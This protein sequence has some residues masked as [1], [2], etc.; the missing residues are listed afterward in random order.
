MSKNTLTK[1]E[2]VRLLDV[3]DLTYTKSKPTNPV[4]ER[5]Q[6]KSY[7]EGGSSTEYKSGDHLVV[8]LQTGTEFIDPLQS[9]LVFDIQAEGVAGKAGQIVGSALNFIRNSQ[10]S[11][12]SGKEMDRV[13]NLNLLQYHLLRNEPDDFIKHNTNAMMLS[14]YNFNNDNMVATGFRKRNE[15]PVDSAVRVMIPLKYISSIFDSEKYM[16][17]HLARGLRI[18]CELEKF[19][20]AFYDALG[21]ATLTGYKIT[22]AFVLTDNYRMADSVLDYLNQEFASKK[23][24]LVY[25]YPSWHTTKSV[26][27]TNDV[28]VEIRRSVSMA[29]DA[30]ACT[31]DNAKKSLVSA[32]SFA[33][34]KMLDSDKSQWRIGSHYL[35]NQQICGVVEHYTQSLYWAN[36]LRG[37]M[38][39]GPDYVHWEG[40]NTSTTG[41]GNS[42]NYGLNKFCATLQRNAIMD[43]SGIQINNSM[44]LACNITLEDQLGTIATRDIN[45]FL[46]HQRRAVLYLENVVLET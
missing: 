15:V 2:I 29:L 6:K 20:T 16:P 23:M 4:V 42:A 8:H 36:K 11:S 31:R 37:D 13:E 12:R 34:V 30:F 1:D 18:D 38:E 14:Q 5:T 22:K 3:N 40:N 10:T 7:A 46:R 21:D 27:S 26:S 39:F 43:L 17:P 41:A 32:D 35:P 45:V 44:T 9:F 33:S 19:E 24:G 28:N 25:E